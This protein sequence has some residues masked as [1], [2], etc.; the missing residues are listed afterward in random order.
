MFKKQDVRFYPN[1]KELND[2]RICHQNNLAYVVVPT[3]KN[4]YWI[5]KYSL[6]DLYTVIYLEE[7]KV[8]K[9]FSQFEADKKIMELYT[10]HSKRFKK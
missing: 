6:K 7:N 4:K 3:K 8:R 9:E 10:Q 5:S 2:M 1:Y